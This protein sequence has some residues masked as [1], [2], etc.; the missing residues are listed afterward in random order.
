MNATPDRVYAISNPDAD[1][2]PSPKKS[3]KTFTMGER[4]AE[5]GS[6]SASL[7]GLSYGFEFKNARFVLIDQYADFDGVLNPLT[8]GKAI[9]RTTVKKQLG[10]ISQTLSGREKNKHAFVFA[11]KGLITQGSASH[12]V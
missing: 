7:R 9:M 2:Q 5:I 10:W 6:P 3:G 1:L 11:H 4:F 12:P 8:E